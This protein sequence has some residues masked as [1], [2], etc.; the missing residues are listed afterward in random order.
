MVAM[1]NTT[2]P[3]RAAAS[4][5]VQIGAARL[6]QPLVLENAATL[7]SKDTTQACMMWA[8]NTALAARN[9]FTVKG[10]GVYAVEGSLGLDCQER[11]GGKSRRRAPM[12][13][14]DRDENMNMASVETKPLP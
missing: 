2:G 10:A 1:Y 8:G 3:E 6:C 11:G 5:P 4:A 14:Y 7:A 12:P 13:Y 9:S